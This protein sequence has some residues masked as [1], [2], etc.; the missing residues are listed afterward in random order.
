MTLAAQLKQILHHE[1]PIGHTMG[2]RVIS[3]DGKQ[4]RLGM[5]FLKAHPR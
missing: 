3:Y 4:L 5:P 1:I 2:I